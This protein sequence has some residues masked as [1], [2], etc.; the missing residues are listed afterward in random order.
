[1]YPLFATIDDTLSA[2]GAP[3]SVKEGTDCRQLCR[4]SE[5]YCSAVVFGRE[6]SHRLRLS[7][8]SSSTIRTLQVTRRSQRCLHKNCYRPGELIF[9]IVFST[10]AFPAGHCS[11]D[12]SAIV[13]VLILA[14]RS[15]CSARTFRTSQDTS[16]ARHTP[17]HQLRHKRHHYVT[18]TSPRTHLH[19]LQVPR[20]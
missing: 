20:G 12:D 19:Q 15:C 7:R 6:S 18:R 13:I 5:P 14:K 8:P 11:Y 17:R 4:D 3:L 1:V 9:T 2:N 16:S 10:P